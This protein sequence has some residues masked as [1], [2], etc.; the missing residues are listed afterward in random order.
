M[1]D[2]NL[3]RLNGPNG[4]DNDLPSGSEDEQ[5]DKIELD[6]RTRSIVHNNASKDDE[7][8]D[9]MPNAVRKRGGSFEPFQFV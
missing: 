7:V 9:E 6:S 4:G 5:G 1:V 8:D 3:E 2:P